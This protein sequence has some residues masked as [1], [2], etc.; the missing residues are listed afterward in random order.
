MKIGS[1]LD[2]KGYGIATP[3][4]SELRYAYKHTLS[5]SNDSFFREAIN[6]AVLEMSEDGTL[7]T[8]K[9]K[10][11]YERSECPS[12]TAKVCLKSNPIIFIRFIIVKTRNLNKVM[13]LIL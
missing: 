1:N 7:N 11:W 9:R 10:W 8:L 12:G 3:V 4:G 5:N 2:S 6:I 13:H